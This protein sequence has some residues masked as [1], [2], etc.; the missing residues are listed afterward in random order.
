MRCAL[1]CAV[2]C[3]AVLCCAVLWCAALR[4]AGSSAHQRGGWPHC[5]ALPNP[6]TPMHTHTPPIPPQELGIYGRLRKISRAGP[7]SM[8]RCGGSAGG[9]SAACPTSVDPCS[10]Q[11]LHCR[12]LP[13]HL[14]RPAPACLQSAAGPVARPLRAGRCGG[15]GQKHFF[16]CG[17][18]EVDRLA[19]RQP[20]WLQGRAASHPLIACRR[21]QAPSRLPAPHTKHRNLSSQPPTPLTHPHCPTGTTP[22]TGTRPPPS[23]PSYHR[24]RACA[25]AALRAGVLPA[26]GLPP[27]RT[28]VQ[29]QSPNHPCSGHA[30]PPTPCRVVQPR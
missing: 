15:E 6:H 11:G 8:F 23:P 14:V 10:Q 29:H 27:A 17:R 24:R 28:P 20:A 4:C 26:A 22:S 9:G 7:L 16:R 5:H 18:A 1:C 13:A 21:W 19:G 2:L 12:R 25:Q 30:W 3:C